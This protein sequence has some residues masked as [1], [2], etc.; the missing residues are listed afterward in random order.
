MGCRAVGWRP[1]AMG[2]AAL[3]G[4]T[5][6]P[7][8][9]VLLWA[10]GNWAPRGATGGSGFFWQPHTDIPQEG[11]GLERTRG[12]PFSREAHRIVSPPAPAPQPCHVEPPSLGPQVPLRPLG[13]NLWMSCHFWLGTQLFGGEA[14]LFT[15]VF[16]LDCTTSSSSCLQG[17]QTGLGPLVCQRCCGWEGGLGWCPLDASL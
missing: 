4:G 9:W 11:P 12:S 17:G 1:C 5:L 8:T 15:S 13:Q 16:P 14:G 10:H 6:L 7:S 3:L 2:K